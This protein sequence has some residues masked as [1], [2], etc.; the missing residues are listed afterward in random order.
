VS[1]NR[2]QNTEQFDF[3]SDGEQAPSG[4]PGS[5]IQG[6]ETSFDGPAPRPRRA[7]MARLAAILA[8]ALAVVPIAVVGGR[9]L[10]GSGAGDSV[11]DTV[12]EASEAMKSHAWDAPPGRNFKE[13]TE[14]GL[15]RYPE[16]TRLQDLRREAAE[17]LVS[18]ALG[19]KYA[20]D[21]TE[22]LRFVHLAL[23]WNPGLTT[24]QH[25]AAELEGPRAPEVAP[26][27]SAAPSAGDRGGKGNKKGG[28]RG[29]D[30][31]GPTAPASAAPSAAAIPNGAA[32][33]P[34]PTPPPTPPP[35]S[36]GP[37]L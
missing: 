27:P 25:L 35:A 1:S 4:H 8:C 15:A 34:S 21:T 30:P 18:D 6:T 3:M 28:P 5:T 2:P 9:K 23:E 24:A 32:L 12:A 13:I 10:G 22:A 7:R 14:A 36:T 19:R 20:G 29:P 16:S 37:W 33:P 31:R 26:T 11:D 17:R